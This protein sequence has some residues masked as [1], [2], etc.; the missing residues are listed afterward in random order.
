MYGLTNAMLGL[1]MGFGWAGIP[2]R[3]CG[4]VPAN[5]EKTDPADPLKTC[6]G[7]T[8]PDMSKDAAAN[9]IQ[10]NVTA[11]CLANQACWR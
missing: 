5:Q 4:L 6:Q 1:G 11:A 2:G 8:C 9:Q 7:W 10:T 3:D